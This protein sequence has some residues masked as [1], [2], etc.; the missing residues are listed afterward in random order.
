M[1]EVAAE[2][3]IF[4]SPSVRA[5]DGDT[6]GG[7]PV[8]LIE[9][10]ASGMPI[11]SS[12]HCDIPNV[13]RGPASRLLAPERDVTGLAE[14]LGWLIDH[15]DEW[16]ALLRFVRDELSERFDSRRQAQQLAAIYRELPAPRRATL[17]LR[18]INRLQN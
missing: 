13:L 6:E 2:H 7:A 16:P 5:Q 12:T 4:L 15:P 1:F 3:R 9:L 10:A 8:A 18:T 14:R 17:A 11:V